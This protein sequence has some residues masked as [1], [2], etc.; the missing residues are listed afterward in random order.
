MVD[1]LKNETGWGIFILHLDGSG[2]VTS[3]QV[4]GQVELAKSRRRGVPLFENG[5][6][7]PVREYFKWRENS[8]VRGAIGT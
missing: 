6:Y 3:D 7:L 1:S 8:A 2:F 5:A 4:R